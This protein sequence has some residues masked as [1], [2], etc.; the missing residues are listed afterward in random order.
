MEFP[1]NHIVKTL[2]VAT[3]QK[4]VSYPI[5]HRS[6]HSDPGIH[7]WLL[8][9]I[10]SEERRHPGKAPAE[11]TQSLV[12]LAT[13]IT[14]RTSPDCSLICTGHQ[15]RQ[16]HLQGLCPSTP[17]LPQVLSELLKKFTFLHNPTVTLPYRNK[18]RVDFEDT[19]YAG[20]RI[21]QGFGSLYCSQEQWEPLW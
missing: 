19:V 8:Q 4:M 16:S 10:S 14:E 20:D 1:D 2:P 12:S 15:W 18:Q 9:L 17:W 11:K 6:Q 7:D 13:A 21:S 3:C 5:R